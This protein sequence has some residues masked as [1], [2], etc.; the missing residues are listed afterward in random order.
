MSISHLLCIH[1]LEVLLIPPPAC[2]CLR[3][4]NMEAAGLV[5]VQSCSGK[6]VTV[7]IEYTIKHDNKLIY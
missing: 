7:C 5:E 6:N 4:L 2:L 1:Y 3:D